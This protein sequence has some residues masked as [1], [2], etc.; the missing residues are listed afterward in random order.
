MTASRIRSRVLLVDSARALI[1]YLR[2]GLGPA[3]FMS[4]KLNTKPNIGVNHR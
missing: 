2:V 4:I 1:V 3:I